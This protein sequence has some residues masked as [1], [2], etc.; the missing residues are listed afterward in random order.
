[1]YSYYVAYYVNSNC[2]FN[3]ETSEKET[4]LIYLLYDIKYFLNDV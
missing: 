3:N 4:D 2:F 1:M